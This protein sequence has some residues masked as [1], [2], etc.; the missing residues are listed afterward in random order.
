LPELPV[1]QGLQLELHV[2]NE[3]SGAVPLGC[4]NKGREAFKK[5]DNVLVAERRF[6]V[7]FF[8]GLPRHADNVVAG[9][10]ILLPISAAALTMARR[11]AA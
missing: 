2:R 11:V 8:A 7:R 10:F 3:A 4:G 6:P 1:A 9:H 5:L